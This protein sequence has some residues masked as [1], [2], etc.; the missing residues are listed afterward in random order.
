ME[1]YPWW[2]EEHKA[3]DLEIR[4]FAQ[5]VMPLDAEMRW[6]REFPWEIFDRISKKGYTGA[7]VPKEYGGLGLGATGA[8]IAAEA[9]NRMP[10][11]GRVF[12]GN[13]LGGLRQI[14]EFGTEEQKGRFLPRIAKGELGAIV[15]TEPFA[16][17]DAAAQEM[18]ARREGDIY[19][20]NGKKRFIVSA[21]VAKRYMVYA[22][23]S[24][25]SEDRNRYRH[26]TAFVV[27]KGFPGFSVEKINEVIGFEN[28]QNG[29][30]NFQDVPIPLENR[31]GE[32]GDG[33][34]VMTAGLNFE[35]TL[36]CAQTVGWMGELLRNVVPYAER[37]VQ[38]GKPTIS[39]TNNQFKI[40]DMMMRWKIA[41]LLTYY[42]AYLWDLGWDITLESNM[43]KVFNCEGV[44]ASSLDGIQVMGGDGL[45]PF[46]PLAAIMNV[47]KVENI[48][49]GTMEACR[50]VIQRTGVRQMAED[51]KMPRRIIHDKLGVPIPAGDL[52][53]RKKVADEE[54]VLRVLAEDYRVNPGLHMS[55]DDLM[56][57]LD[58]DDGRLDEVL[59]GLERKG[60]VKLLRDKKG[61]ALAKATYDGLSQANPSEHYQWF[62][63]WIHEE[64]VF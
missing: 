32:E 38:F 5:E 9:M 59:L 8:C 63:S 18:R 60:L 35:R 51:L 26:L 57:F 23:T 52:P 17:T 48:A 31:V 34:R 45:T 39:F 36:I 20:L 53:K 11:P 29:V 19:L 42:T 24:E 30:L 37:R 28:I 6:K 46:Y 40:A 14:I 44:L 7:G 12:V 4:A 47:A 62:P 58:V 56:T 10:G 27:E 43:A 55:R 25:D 41:R 54:G 64:N 16:G 49:G 22:R 33:W 61:I 13:M 50:M 2:T 1:V 15:I 21:G 3:F